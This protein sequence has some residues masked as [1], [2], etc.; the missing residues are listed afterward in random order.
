[1]TTTI[2]NKEF[3]VDTAPSSSPQTYSQAEML[4]ALKPHERSLTWLKQT[5]EFIEKTVGECEDDLLLKLKTAR[6]NYTEWGLRVFLEFFEAT[7]NSDAGVKRG[8]YVPVPRKPSMTRDQWQVSFWKEHPKRK[9][10]EEFSYYPT[11]N[12]DQ[13]NDPET[14]QAFGVEICEFVDET[15]G[16]A[17]IETAEQTDIVVGE[18]QSNLSN[19]LLSMNSGL[20]QFGKTLEAQAEQIAAAA[21]V[22]GFSKGVARGQEIIAGQAPEA[23]QTPTVKRQTRKK[24]S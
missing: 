23:G 17:A 18:L 11:L 3:K 15:E 14:D 24:P 2:A 22:S 21:I 10:E 16:I 7:R 4:T 8:K 19:N 1:M 20:L 9:P 13:A 12:T 6:G 5:R